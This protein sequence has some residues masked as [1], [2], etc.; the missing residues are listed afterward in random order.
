MGITAQKDNAREAILDATDRLFER[1]GYRKTTVEDIAQESDVCRGT[2]YQHFKNKEEIALSWLGRY[3]ERVRER[4]REIAQEPIPP[5]ERIRKMLLARILTRLDN[6]QHLSVSLDELFSTMRPLILEHR[7][8]CQEGEAELLAA[9]LNESR[10]SGVFVFEDALA[11]ARLLTLAT[12]CLLPYS[13]S[14]RQLGERA[15]IEIR[16]RN[17]ID[18]LLDGVRIREDGTRIIANYTNEHE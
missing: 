16:A 2:V 9:V 8:K 6:V 14:V 10:A 1:Y 15:E 5:T 11:T 13:L 7:Q 12:A 4:M 3:N 18:L 17:L